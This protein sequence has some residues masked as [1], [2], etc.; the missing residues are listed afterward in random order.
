MEGTGRDRTMGG[1]D[2]EETDGM[3]RDEM[4]GAGWTDE[5]GRGGTG[6]TGWD[7]IDWT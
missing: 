5:T 7:R 1:D 3:G 2:M 6:R 4:E